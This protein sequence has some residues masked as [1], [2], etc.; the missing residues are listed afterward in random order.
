MQRSTLVIPSAIIVQD[1][2]NGRFPYIPHGYMYTYRY[3]LMHFGYHTQSTVRL[4]PFPLSDPVRFG[5][6]DS[7]CREKT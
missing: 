7:G 1:K 2:K 5:T 6:S 3:L 4:K